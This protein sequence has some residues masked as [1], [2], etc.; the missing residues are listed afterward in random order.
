[1]R[2]LIAFTAIL[3]LYSCAPKTSEFKTGTWRGVLHLQGKEV[4]FLFD[5]E[6]Q[7]S[8][9]RAYL[10][11]DT[12][13][14][15]LDE[16][17][18]NGDTVN[19]VLHVFDA[20]L[21]AKIDGDQLSG[22]FIKNYALD[23]SI[24]FTA[25][26]G[27]SLLFPKG[28]DASEDFSGKYQVT[29]YDE[30]DPIPSVGIFK[31]SGNTLKG[32]FLTPTGDYRYLDGIVSANEMKLST[33]DGNHAFLFVATKAGDSLRGD[34]YSGKA[35]HETFVAIKNENA[36]L[37]DLESLTFLKPGYEKL[38]FSFP[39]VNGNK[40]SP[41]DDRFKN[42]VLVL[43]IFGTWCPNCMDETKFLTKWYSENKDRGVEILGLAYERKD[44]FDYA[45]GRVIKMKEKWNVPYDFVIAGVNDKDKASET[46]PA[47]NRVLAFP[48]TIFI[49]KDG[50]VKSIHTGFSGP[51]TGV[52][53]EQF[54]QHF[55]E[56]VNELLAEKSTSSIK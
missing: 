53:Y 21:K 37:P 6:K 15:L 50:K 29:F 30:K 39:D 42:K 51:G 40:V 34:Y 23:A 54:V 47:L 4:P 8:S 48:T 49:G 24:P 56:T 16:I 52:Y 46:L 14:I 3:F 19:M 22:T 26:H 20:S 38:E 12:E 28:A 2:V 17:T 33:Y 36:S 31:Q 1:M 32:T 5:V 7:G 44:D 35:H 55:N 18:V 10:R 9:Y 25:T 13:R 11:N 43:Q 27:D 45:R 41:S